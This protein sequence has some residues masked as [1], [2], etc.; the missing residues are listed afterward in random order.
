LDPWLATTRARP[1]VPNQ[2]APGWTRSPG[3]G[4]A[5]V[6]VRRLLDEVIPAVRRGADAG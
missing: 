6:I 2:K 5:D 3:I 1:A 4:D